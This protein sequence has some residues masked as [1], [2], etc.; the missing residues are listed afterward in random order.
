M[1]AVAG[2]G[3]PWPESFKALASAYRNNAPAM[4]EA[5]R[6]CVS[7][8]YEYMRGASSPRSRKTRARFIAIGWTRNEL[9]PSS[10]FDQDVDTTD[11]Y[12]EGVLDHDQVDWTNPAVVFWQRL[13]DAHCKKS[14]LKPSEAQS[15]EFGDPH[16]YIRSA[17][18]SLWRDSR[19]EHLP[20]C[21]FKPMARN[22]S[23]AA[24]CPVSA[25][26]EK[27]SPLVLA[28][29]EVHEAL[30]RR[31]IRKGFSFSESNASAARTMERVDS[32]RIR[33]LL[34]MKETT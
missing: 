30:R 23:C 5:L 21:H 28:E 32:D 17:F 31:A 14:A 4:S 25:Q 2:I 7:S 20:G 16:E 27:K 3:L 6:I 18:C 10:L 34:R 33:R 12:N 26:V 11:K 13:Y 15:A 1:I 22:I 9:P 24:G 29:D 19:I 8:I